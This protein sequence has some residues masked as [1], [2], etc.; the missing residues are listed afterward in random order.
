MVRSH[1]YGFTDGKEKVALIP[2][3]KEE[4]FLLRVENVGSL[5]ILLE[6]YVLHKYMENTVALD[7][8]FLIDN[9][10]IM[11]RSRKMATEN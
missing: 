8:V 4:I 1:V 7:H 5:G 3:N 9:A 11:Y 2:G 10:E 6:L